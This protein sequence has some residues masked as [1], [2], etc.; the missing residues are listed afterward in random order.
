[1]N[2]ILAVLFLF[3]LT[4]T[5]V[6]G[7]ITTVKV[8]PKVERKDN[9]PYDA[10]RNFLGEDVAK[11][12][13]QEFYLNGKAE[14]L[15]KY[16]YEGFSIDYR[17]SSLIDK[18]NVYKCCD[19]YNS[20]YTELAGKYFL[21]L[22][23]IK[24]PRAAE[25]EYLYGKKW[26]LK[27]QEKESKD[28]VYFEYDSRFEY[29]FPF[30]LVSYFNQLKKDQIGKIY[31]LRGKNWISS[32]A[33]SDIRT[34][35]PVS[36]F[37]A[38]ARWKVVDVSVEERFYT[39]SLIIENEKGEQIP[40]AVDRLSSYLFAI[41]YLKA[42]EYRKRFGSENWQVVLAGKVKIGMTK[43]MCEISWGKPKK[44]NETI[45]AGKIFEQ[46]VYADNYLY[47]NNGILSSMQ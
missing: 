22:D 46:W 31:I 15:R 18:S 34:G 3:L 5:T 11:Y 35:R 24:H 19:S 44:I 12:I 27:L 43:E 40:L 45:A 6:F 10:T 41:E 20:K 14:S 1:M 9:T 38:G 8:A 47:F 29:S 42:E 25:S 21:V 16:G 13:G 26:Y 2:R 32:D 17:K 30:I 4:A 7:Q 33:M 36:N 39:L 28:I 37:V 23:S